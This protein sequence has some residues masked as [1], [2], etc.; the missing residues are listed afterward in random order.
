MAAK[1]KAKTTSGTA[2]DYVMNAVIDDNQV[3][4]IEKSFTKFQRN[5]KSKPVYPKLLTV[6]FRNLRDCTKF[7]LLI[8][9]NI[10]FAERLID[11]KIPA[12]R[13]HGKWY[14]NGEPKVK[15]TTKG[16]KDEHVLH[17]KGMPDF[18]QDKHDFIFHSLKLRFNNA[19]AYAFFANLVRQELKEST[20]SI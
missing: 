9:R 6:K 4:A 3:K 12:W 16:L 7:A 17:W 5:K 1:R 11:F 14:F 20:S 13:N 8:Q 10:D 19:K 2:R 15:A 18:E